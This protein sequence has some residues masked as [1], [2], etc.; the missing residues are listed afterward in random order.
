MTGLGVEMLCHCPALTLLSYGISWVISKPCTLIQLI[1]YR[2]PPVYESP[3][4]PTRRR[5]ESLNPITRLHGSGKS[6]ILDAI[7]FV[8]G[9]T[10]MPIVRASKRREFQFDHRSRRKWKV[11]H[12]RCEIF[13]PQNCKHADDSSAQV[14]GVT[15]P[16]RQWKVKH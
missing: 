4:L 9:I 7:C 15:V 1:E 2:C 5:D 3:L 16:Q 10:N 12:P 14:T 11:K 8:L 6:N 13:R